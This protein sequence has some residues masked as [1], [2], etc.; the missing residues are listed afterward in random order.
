MRISA[1]FAIRSARSMGDQ[2]RLTPGFTAPEGDA[3][4]RRV[5]TA[6]RLKTKSSAAP[7][8]ER[9]LMLSRTRA[10]HAIVSQHLC[11]RASHERARRDSCS[12][13]SGE[14]GHNRGHKRTQ[15]DAKARR[16][17]QTRFVQTPDNTEGCNPG[18][19][20]PKSS[21]RTAEPFRRF[22]S[23]SR[24]GEKAVVTIWARGYEYVPPKA[25]VESIPRPTARRLSQRDRACIAREIDAI[26]AR[27]R[28]MEQG[29]KLL[30]LA[31]RY[32]ATMAQIA[33]VRLAS[34]SRQRER[35]TES[36][37]RP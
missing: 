8:N 29:R 37:S 28:S 19:N 31:H 30:A 23:G 21:D 36:A 4:L 16:R 9:L 14:Y 11:H 3:S 26:Q 17:T 15:R 35:C 2:L 13:A 24:E 7:L 25:A 33:D 10:R 34:S 20:G 6:S 22:D 32:G 12:T 5:A 1:G 18:A 27:H